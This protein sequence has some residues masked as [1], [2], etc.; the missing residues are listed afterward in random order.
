MTAD[1]KKVAVVLS[2]GGANGAYEVGVLKALVSGRSQ[3]TD[4]QPLVPDIVTGTSTGAF[5]AAFLVSQL[6][7]Y[8]A[9]AVGNLERFWVERLAGGLRDNGVF[10]LRGNPLDLLDPSSYS[11][12]PLRPFQRLLSDS[13]ILAWEG[14]QRAVHFFT[15]SGPLSQRLIESFDFGAFISL[16]PLEQNLQEIDYRAIRSSKVWLKI[17][18]TNWAT[19]ELRV[20]WNHDMTDAFGPLAVRASTAV[21]GIFPAAEF[22][23]QPFVDGSVLLN[24]PLSLAINAGADVLHVIYLDPQVSNLPLPRLPQAV[25]TLMRVNQIGWAA[26]YHND[27]AAAAR[28]NRSL[29]ALEK[30]R[31]QL[32]ANSPVAALLEDIAQAKPSPGRGPLRSVEIHCYNPVDPLGGDLSLLTFDRER[33]VALVERG[34]QDAI[35]HSHEDG[36][37]VFPGPERAAALRTAPNRAA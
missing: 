26:S 11:P 20:F 28:I 17:A 19:G 9:A 37:D 8:G 13:G 10:R 3:A 31:S 1:G 34:F 35:A 21:P 24:T 5:N 15:S 4:Y 7:A 22:G 29:A 18:A 33:I 16:E 36:H 30:A 27:I 12:N 2:A 32:P 23:S 6:D 25:S 14:L